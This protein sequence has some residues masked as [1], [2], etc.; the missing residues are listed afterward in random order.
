MRDED[1][2]GAGRFVQ[3]EENFDDVFGTC[4]KYS[5]VDVYAGAYNGE[6]RKAGVDLL[7]NHP[8]AA[9]FYHSAADGIFGIF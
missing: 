9:L 4:N 7:E 6:Y 1:Q 2:R 3:T 8:T 5:S